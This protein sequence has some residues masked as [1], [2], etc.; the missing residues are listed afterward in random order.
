MENN[1]TFGESSSQIFQKLLVCVEGIQK[2]APDSIGA[3]LNFSLLSCDEERDIYCFRCDTAGWMRNINGTLHGGVCATILD[4]AM[5]F[6]VR[7]IQPGNG[8]S[9]T[10]EM[11]ISYHRPVI[12]G[13]KLDIMVQV[14]SR[15]RSLMHLRA[16]AGMTGTDKLC[17]SATAVY[18][19]KPAKP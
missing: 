2:T 13:E 9:P 7:C 17:I 3:M 14:L 19:Y 16:E 1:L 4:Q 10:A 5:G 11:Q 18:C 15:G 8:I 12:P 6:V